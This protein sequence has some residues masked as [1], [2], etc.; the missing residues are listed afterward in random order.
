MG[1]AAAPM[2]VAPWRYSGPVL[3]KGL[4]P[5]SSWRPPGPWHGPVW[6]G[7]RW[8]WPVWLEERLALPP[9]PEGL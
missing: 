2:P 9:V 8:R 6:R 3:P 7:L 5:L 1:A 4:V